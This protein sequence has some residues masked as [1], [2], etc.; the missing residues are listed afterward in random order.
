MLLCVIDWQNYSSLCDALFFCISDDMSL[1][2]L[3]QMHD[4]SLC[5]TPDDMLQRKMCKLDSAYDKISH[6][7]ITEHVKTGK[8]ASLQKWY[9]PTQIESLKIWL[10]SFLSSNI[11]IL[12]F[13]TFLDYVQS[14]K[15]LCLV[16]HCWTSSPLA[17]INSTFFV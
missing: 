8:Y 10:C 16:N 1:W 4:L 15:S 5:D 17:P 7:C 14:Q 9:R 11:D 12:T 2:I 3:S 6:D 13:F